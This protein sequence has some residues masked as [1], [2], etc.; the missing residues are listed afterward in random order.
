M[1]IYK[2]EFQKAVIQPKRA[3]NNDV[4]NSI[5]VSSDNKSMSTVVCYFLNFLLHRFPFMSILCQPCFTEKVSVH[6]ST[7]VRLFR[8]T[9]I[10]ILLL[11]F[12][13]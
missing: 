11:S 1:I 12:G 2:I 8:K 10:N 3:S 5:E 4:S 13:Y 9:K 7:F 6:A